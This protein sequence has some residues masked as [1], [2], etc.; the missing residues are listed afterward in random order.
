M[1]YNLDSFGN[2]IRE[3]RE[4]FRY[5][6]KE[7][8]DISYVNV[9]T[10]RRIETNFGSVP[11]RDVL[12]SLLVIVSILKA[13]NLCVPSFYFHF[14]IFYSKIKQLYLVIQLYCQHL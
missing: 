6:R 12:E 1:F 3:L 10:I 9:D 2:L 4:N 14:Y 5:S 7:L 8:S 13:R 11:S